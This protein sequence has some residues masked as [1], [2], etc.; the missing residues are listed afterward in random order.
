MSPSRWASD[1]NV[2]IPRSTK[3][4]HHVGFTMA[5]DGSIESRTIGKVRKEHEA[6]KARLDRIDLDIPRREIAVVRQILDLIDDEL[7]G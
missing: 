7:K 2:S 4:Q 6:I 3:I 5:A 1:S